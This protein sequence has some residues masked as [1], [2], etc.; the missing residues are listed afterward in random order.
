MN[1]SHNQAN[2]KV[3]VLLLKQ[4]AIDQGIS[5]QQIAERTGLQQSNVSRIFSL[6]YCPRLDLL[7]DIAEAIGVNFFIESK[8]S[9]TDLNK[10]FEKAMT[11]L[12]RR[13]DNLPKN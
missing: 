3:F 4:I 10:I 8:N 11:E 2:W 13:P 9:T 7:L 1:T 6:K 5:Q 12:G